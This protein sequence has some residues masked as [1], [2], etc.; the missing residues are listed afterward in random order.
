MEYELFKRLVTQ[1]IKEYL[2][3]VFH[4]YT[5]MVREV[6]KVNETE[7]AFCLLPPGD[8]VNVAIPTLYFD[9]L[10]DEFAEDEDLEATLKMAAGI[11]LNWSGVELP[12]LVD[13]H[14]KDHMDRI[15]S[16]LINTERNKELLKKVPHMDYYGMSV[17]YRVIAAMGENGISSAIVTNE[18]LEG[19]GLGLE[20]LKQVAGPNTRAMFPFKLYEGTS[21]DMYVVT[22]EEC[23]FGAMSMFYREEM[24]NLA[25][26]IG[27]DFFIM[28]TSVHEF[29]AVS[30]ET[31]DPED[32]IRMLAAGNEE[33]TPP[34]EQL[35]NSIYRY[36]AKE[37][38]IVRVI[39]YS[40]TKI[41]LG[42]LE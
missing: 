28:P 11:F 9:E 34:S 7:E 18:M 5:P 39:S 20:D 33:I 23:Y 26:R 32:L 15:V 10:Y 37:G 24:Q 31:T 12:E 42:E 1:R 21:D 16:N 27:G 4:D 2:P 41:A 13:F 19:T 17:I 35:S 25:R 3:P 36:L 14:I 6:N 29:F 40:K 22:N 8:T 30:V 38:V